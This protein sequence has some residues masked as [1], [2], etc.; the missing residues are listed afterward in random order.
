MSD[1]T[2]VWRG[3]FGDYKVIGTDLLS[4]NDLATAVFISLFSDAALPPDEVAPDGSD[5]PRGWWASDKAYPLGS[6]IWTLLRA[7]R[8]Q[9]TLAQA[10]GFAVAA[11]QWVID[12][13]VAAAVDVAVEW[14][15]PTQLSM[16]VTLRRNDGTSSKLKYAWAWADATL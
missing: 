3:S 8:T 11:L 14:A 4:G 2:T 1:I 13:G 9:D 5:D 10:Q 6:L 7:K 12:D 15:T 16:Q